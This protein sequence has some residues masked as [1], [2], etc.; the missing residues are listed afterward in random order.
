MKK[1]SNASTSGPPAGSMPAVHRH[2]DESDRPTSKIRRD[3]GRFKRPDCAYLKRGREAL[4]I[5][6]W[7]VRTLYQL[8]KLENLRR[9]AESLDIDI[10]GLSETVL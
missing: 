2:R 5:G 10:L 6:T 3:E 1:A 9:E 4:K 8:G 7:N